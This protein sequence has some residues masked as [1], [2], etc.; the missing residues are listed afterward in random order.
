MKK[1]VKNLNILT[2]GVMNGTNNV[3]VGFVDCVEQSQEHGQ[4]GHC[5]LKFHFIN[6]R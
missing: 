6:N 2:R 3:V 1:D 4:H 5:Y